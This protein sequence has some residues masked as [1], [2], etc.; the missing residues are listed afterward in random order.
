M[1]EVDMP[2]NNQDNVPTLDDLKPNSHQYHKEAEAAEKDIPEKKVGKIV[3]NNV[4]RKKKTLGRRF[5][6]IF[7]KDGESIGDIKTY[8]LEEVLVP[9]IKENI[10][11]MVNGAIGMLFFGEARR[12]AGNRSQGNGTR[13][14]YG[15]YFNGGGNNERR[16]RMA[17]STR[18]RNERENI[19]DFIFESRA[20]AE[21]VYDEMFELL[22]S[23][24]QVTVADYLDMLGISSEFTDNKYGWTNLSGMKVVHARGGYRL[25]LPRET[26]LAR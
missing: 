10:A 19:N 13:V 24:G 2:T 1:A 15:G 18:N 23:Y 5:V 8:L 25:E 21:Q 7:F 16:E 17:N 6:D 14:N 12:R 11:D 4:I 3:S 20:D 9:A 26:A 22:D